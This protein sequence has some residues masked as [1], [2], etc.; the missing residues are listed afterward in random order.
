MTFFIS[1]NPALIIIKLTDLVYN[2]SSIAAGG[3][4]MAKKS[5]DSNTRF[6][7]ISLFVTLLII[8][9]IGVWT[10]HTVHQKQQRAQQQVTQIQ[11]NADQVVN[12]F[13]GQLTQKQAHNIAHNYQ[14]R[15]LH[16]YTT[17][18]HVEAAWRQRIE[19]PTNLHYANA[20][21][22]TEIYAFPQK[23]VYYY[24]AIMYDQQTKKMVTANT[25]N[26][27]LTSWSF[28]QT[29]AEYLHLLKKYNRTTESALLTKIYHQRDQLV[30]QVRQAQKYQEVQPNNPDAD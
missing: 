28:Y 19:R 12:L 24:L 15:L 4:L 22:F 30:Q 6:I 13:Q 25:L 21:Y 17:D 26:K 5:T 9:G 7:L 10:G 16:T 18:V 20:N 29:Q 23:K 3:F 1:S 11:T 8:S 27:Q 2:K 14:L